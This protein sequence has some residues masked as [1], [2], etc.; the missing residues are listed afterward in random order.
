[1][2]QSV[3]SRRPPEAPSAPESDSR[4]S[5]AIVFGGIAFV[6]AFA[7]Y[8][9]YPTRSYTFDEAITVG[10]F[11]KGHTLLTPFTHQYLFN[12]HPGMSFLLSVATHLF[13]YHAAVI[14]AVPCII[15]ALSVAVLGGWLMWRWGWAAGL[16]GAL[17]LG[18]NSVFLPEARTAR[19]YGTLA[20]CTIVSSI[21]LADDRRSARA[22][23]LF[24]GAI[25]LG[26]ATHLYML[27]VVAAEGT[28]VALERR[29]Q[30][31]LDLGIGVA[32]GS[33]AYVRIAQHML[34]TNRH[35]RGHKNPTFLHDASVLLLGRWRI[36][37]LAVVLLAVVGAV[38][39]LRRRSFIVAGL[40]PVALVLY[41]WK[42]QQPEFLY[43]RFLVPAVAGLAFLGAV[44]VAHHRWLLVVA[45]LASGVM[46]GNQ[47]S[48]L[49]G[50][51]YV[52]RAAGYVDRARELRV[53]PCVVGA[54]TLVVYTKPPP[55]FH[56]LPQRRQCDVLLRIAG[57]NNDRV[58]R[59]AHLYKHGWNDHGLFVMSD[60]PRW[61]LEPGYVPPR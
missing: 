17:L 13:G 3:L 18:T 48:A 6:A 1:L 28:Y 29:W 36:A 46:L 5:H 10:L 54:A 12:N 42:V 39:V 20:L 11:V 22:R 21:V 26:V 25:A 56:R 60:V 7:L 50:T 37:I 9:S 23:A 59:V 8:F 43:A 40:V 52:E 4:K 16:A 45:L 38:Y 47:I 24:V 49:R 34:E 51:S 31:V 41:E 19:G 35:K 33:L 14:R 27:L 30:R 2:I 15:G 58:R 57:W 53:R 32:I 55:D 44:A 61:E